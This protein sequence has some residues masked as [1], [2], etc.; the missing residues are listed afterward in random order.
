[1]SFTDPQSV[2]INAV[3]QSL[4]RVSTA[5]FEA[6]YQKDDRTVTLKIRHTVTAKRLRTNI[7]L[8]QTKIATDPLVTTTN[9]YYTSSVSLTIDRPTAGFSNTEI[10]YL[11]D[12]I[13]LWLT[14]SSSANAIKAIA[15][16]S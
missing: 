13:A 5:P 7:R 8:E 3:A 10:K 16:E 12:A 6:T 2:T 1:M 15:L 14:T 11:T 4:A 9:N